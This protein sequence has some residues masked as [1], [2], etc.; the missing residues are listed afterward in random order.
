MNV[1]NAF[2]L[3]AGLLL[4][5]IAFIYQVWQPIQWALLIVI[6]IITLGIFDMLQSRQA[7]R[8]NF[9]VIGHFRYWS[10]FFG[11][12][13]RQYFFSNDRE[14]L[15]FNRAERNWVYRASK[16]IDTMI[17]FGSTNAPLHV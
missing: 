16:N 13:F 4:I 15:P 9:P 11:E 7:I 3:I 2:I 17:G 5:S 10:E 8:R 6:P 12:F 1:R 14:E